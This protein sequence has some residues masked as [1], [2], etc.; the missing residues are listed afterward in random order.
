[1][2]KSTFSKASL[3]PLLH[4]PLRPDNDW[5]VFARALLEE[6][7]IVIG[8]CVTEDYLILSS[9]LKIP[10]LQKSMPT[11]I[12]KALTGL[13]LRPN[14]IKLVGKN[15]FPN[16]LKKP[17]LKLSNEVFIVFLIYQVL[18]SAGFKYHQ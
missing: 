11:V 12:F 10:P 17:R 6:D 15:N 4:S 8:T 14:L 16:L 9:L 5:S 1:M 2:I 3:L 7:K 18:K 13:D